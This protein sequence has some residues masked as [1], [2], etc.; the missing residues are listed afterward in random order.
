[1]KK[2]FHALAIFLFASLAAFAD[3]LKIGI[4]I[5]LT[6]NNANLGMPQREVI[7]LF[8]KEL[9]TRQTRHAYEFILEDDQLTGRLT[10]E[11]C[12]KFLNLDHV[13][14]IISLGSGSGNIVAPRAEQAKVLHLCIGASDAK[15]T[16]GRNYSFIHWAR[17][18]EEAVLFANLVEKFGS[19][20]VVFLTQRQQG[21]M[22]I[23]T[24]AQK[25]LE[26]QKLAASEVYYFNPGERDFRPLLAKIN[27]TGA[28]LLVIEAFSPEAN[29]ILRQYKQLGLTMRLTAIESPDLMDHREDAA[30][31]LYVSA[32]NPAPEFVAKLG[33]EATFGQPYTYDALN[34]LV[35]AFE[36]CA[37]P[38]SDRAAAVAYLKKVKDYPGAVGPVTVAPDNIFH[39]PA[40]LYVLD[41]SGSA[42]PITLEELE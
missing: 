28:D 6:G 11:A 13:A 18:E 26:A 41:A 22:A 4:T 42:K 15:I 25:A 31:L 24:E 14:G 5:P 33:H 30:G 20:K 3:V 1:M 34:L 10:A 35:A 29:I 40:G 12:N 16:A 38:N 36:E 9:A 27:D 23:T 37:A 21:L 39:S 7:E 17:P 8:E 32:A 2:P 19:K